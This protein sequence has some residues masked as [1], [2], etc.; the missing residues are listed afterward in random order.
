MVQ[1]GNYIYIMLSIYAEVILAQ[2]FQWIFKRSFSFLCCYIKVKI[3]YVF[4]LQWKT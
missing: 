1:L 4:V 2:N 3:R